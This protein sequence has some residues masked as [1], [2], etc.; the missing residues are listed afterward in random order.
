MP[1]SSVQLGPLS[2]MVTGELTSDL[3]TVTPSAARDRGVM[4]ETERIKIA[5]RYFICIS[6]KK[7]SLG[8]C[9]GRRVFV[10]L[11]TQVVIHDAAGQLTS[12]NSQRQR[13]FTLLQHRGIELLG[14]LVPD[15]L[16]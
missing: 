1:L 4:T 15:A 7:T 5:S 16:I 13:V 8:G 3:A 14:V 12:G 11:Q 10:Q 9:G 6:M 2:V